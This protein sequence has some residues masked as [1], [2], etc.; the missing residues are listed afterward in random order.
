MD[1]TSRIHSPS[2]SLSMEVPSHSVLTTVILQVTNQYQLV[3]YYSCILIVE[4]LN[5]DVDFYDDQGFMI[6][7]ILATEYSWKYRY[8]LSW[9]LASLPPEATSDT[10][11]TVIPDTPSNPPY[12]AS[13]LGC[14]GIMG[15]TSKPASPF[16]TQMRLFLFPNRQPPH[17][18][19]QWTR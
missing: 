14:I 10:P 13:L 9:L 7:A 16:P 8:G 18:Q 6:K 15:N 11:A 12:Q 19:F 4:E 1:L 17:Q 2:S 5:T 3:T